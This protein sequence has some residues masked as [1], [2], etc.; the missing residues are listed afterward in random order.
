MDMQCEPG[1]RRQVLINWLGLAVLLAL[2]VAADP[3]R[4]AAA[5]PETRARQAAAPAGAGTAIL[6]RRSVPSAAGR[7]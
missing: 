5:P 6:R 3:G 4:G 7:W 2:G 1:S